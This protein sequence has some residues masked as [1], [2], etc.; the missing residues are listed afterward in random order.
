MPSQIKI[1]SSMAT[2]QILAELARKFENK[3]SLSVSI[4]SVGGVDA[5]KRVLA[6]EA[7]DAV[8]L[9]SNAIDQLIAS[10]KI[11][12]KRFDLM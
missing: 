7:F 9:A 10:G 2:K 8:I 1:I 5:A 3:S 11:V 4:E 12:G 6:G